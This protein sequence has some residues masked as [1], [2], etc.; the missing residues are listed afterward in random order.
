[1]LKW[2][3]SIVFL[4]LLTLLLS[5][6]VTTNAETD[7]EVN[8]GLDTGVE[9]FITIASSFL[10]I[11]LFTVSLVSYVYDRRTRLLFVMAAFFFFALKGM[12]LVLSDLN[13]QRLLSGFLSVLIKPY[14]DILVPFSRLLDFVVLILFFVGMIKK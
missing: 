6:H 8:E 9:L 7:D 10:S 12:I 1:M 13:N 14:L 5:S 11:I 2:F 4:L 3:N